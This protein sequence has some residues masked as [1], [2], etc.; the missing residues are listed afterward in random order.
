[1][2]ILMQV[3]FV[4]IYH[5]VAPYCFLETNSYFPETCYLSSRCNLQSLE[6]PCSLYFLQPKKKAWYCLSGRE[7]EMGNLIRSR[8]LIKLRRRKEWRG[9]LARNWALMHLVYPTIL[10][11]DS[12]SGL[13]S[14][15]IPLT[16]PITFSAFCVWHPLINPLFPAFS[17]V[18]QRNP[19]DSA[20]SLQQGNSLGSYVCCFS[21]FIL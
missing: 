15:L 11:L 2:W 5:L 20:Q 19:S 16:S 1:M 14:G 3:Y 8:H 21:C 13:C 17:I 9:R 7:R 6:T 10:Y 12:I 18:S 4:Y